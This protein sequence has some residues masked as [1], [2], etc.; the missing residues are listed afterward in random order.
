MA[1]GTDIGNRHGATRIGRRAMLLGVGATLLSGM[2]FHAAASPLMQAFA[3]DTPRRHLRLAA[4]QAML[5][6]HRRENRNARARI[7]GAA[8]DVWLSHVAR[9]AS[10]PV[11]TRINAVQRF[12]N[13]C[14]YRPDRASFGCDD[15]WATPRELLRGGGDCED[16]AAA[17]YLALAESGVAS[18]DLR[19]VVGTLRPSERV[20]AVTIVRANATAW[21]LDN[22]VAGPV[23]VDDYRPFAPLYAIAGDELHLFDRRRHG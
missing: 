10:L 1:S 22:G 2:A 8:N 13:A 23:A 20:H 14:R 16:F 4:W 3:D 17:K 15:Y 11:G 18:A 7:D 12:A 19:L 5:L 9:M 21:V 6:R